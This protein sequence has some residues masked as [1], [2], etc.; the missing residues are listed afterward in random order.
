[1]C[2]SSYKLEHSK[3]SVWLVVCL[4]S[5]VL[6]KR[7]SNIKLVLAFCLMLHL[8]RAELAAILRSVLL[9]Q[10]TTNPWLQQKQKGMQLHHRHKIQLHPD[11]PPAR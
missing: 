10:E 6:E 9:L 11:F 2:R 3:A 1:M 5:L 4:Q 8:T 7:H